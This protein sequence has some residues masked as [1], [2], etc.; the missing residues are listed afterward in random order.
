MDLLR[1]PVRTYAWGSR[2]AIPE[3]LGEATPAAEPQAELWMGAHPVA[4][5]TVLRDGRA[6]SLLACIESDPAAELGDS[7]AAEYGPRLPFLL[8]VLAAESPLS[9]QAHPDAGQ[10]VEG[11]AAENSRGVPLDAPNRNYRDASHKP[12]LLCAL[13][14]FEALCGFRPVADTLR[15]VDLLGVP[16]LAPFARPLRRVGGAAGLRETFAALTAVPAD[17]RAA[18]LAAVIEACGHCATA[19]C[20]FAAQCRW[21]VE[22]GRAHPG[23][24]GV[25]CS[26]LL[27]L[28]QLAPGEAIFL[29]AGNLHA[30][31]RGVGVEVMANSDNVLRGGLTAKHVDV[32]ELLRV[33]DFRPGPAPV[34]RPVRAANGVETYPTP[35]PEFRLSRLALRPGDVVGIDS[36]GP[37]ILL[38]V[39][40]SVECRSGESRLVLR[41][42]ASAFVPAGEPAPDLRGQGVVFRVT[43]GDTQ[44][45]DAGAEITG[46][47]DSSHASTRA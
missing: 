13:T 11:F 26:L 1:N 18:L 14:P 2:T 44:Y 3:L 22:F 23:D 10:A 8:K 16:E 35:A 34:I 24:A 46:G 31:L 12:E 4:P 32:P 37:Q 36:A 29:G 21:T 39:A 45:P 20:E 27:N 7:V 41:R 19:E 15:L 25:L 17:P 43:T 40:G 42:G 47:A 28:V 33:V 6:R 5:S 38:C 30:Y 9:L